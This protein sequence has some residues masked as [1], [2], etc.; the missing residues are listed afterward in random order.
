MQWKF[1]QKANAFMGLAWRFDDDVTGFLS[2]MKVS[3]RV[4]RR[5]RN[6]YYRSTSLYTFHRTHETTAHNVLHS[7]AKR[8]RSIALTARGGC[9]GDNQVHTYTCPPIARNSHPRANI[10]SPVYPPVDSLSHKRR[11]PRVWPRPFRW[12]TSA[13]SRMRAQRR[14]SP[15]REPP[16]FIGDTL[17]C[18]LCLRTGSRR[19]VCRYV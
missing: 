10:T 1:C 11:R 7:L 5:F 15:R 14:T 6:C 16:L 12:M 8:A 18:G 4:I 17:W 19:S 3:P 2:R 9:Y 13:A